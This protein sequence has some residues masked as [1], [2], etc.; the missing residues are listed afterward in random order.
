MRRY[1]FWEAMLDGAVLGKDILAHVDDPHEGLYRKKTQDGQYEPVLIFRKRGELAARIG[2]FNKETYAP[3]VDVWTW[4]C[5]HAVSSDEFH[6]AYH[7]GRFSDLDE[8][9][10]ASIGHN[11]P[12]D[13]EA[14]KDQIST[15][16]EAAG[17]YDNIK[18]DEQ[19][20]KAQSVRARLLKLRGDAEDMH[21]NVKA[22][23]LKAS[24]AVDGLYLPI[25]KECTVITKAISKA[26]GVYETAKG[27]D[28][29]KQVRGGYGRAASVRE[30]TIITAITDY[31]ALLKH[32][33]NHPA[34]MG[35]VRDCANKDV[36]SGKSVYGVET[37]TRK[38][39]R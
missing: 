20:S 37:E 1:E 14:L 29:P 2:Y 38:E 9:V 30:V 5:Q 10:A 18:D 6:K 31:P 26:L 17:L 8:T 7:I 11:R 13:W 19:A 32:Y 24:R 34:V 21:K 3:A 23:Y 22:P 39:V 25:I 33:A 35:A 36:R 16:S 12:D 15:V 28:A 4:C 27:D